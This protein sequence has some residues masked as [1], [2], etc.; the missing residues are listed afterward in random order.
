MQGA[1]RIRH[2]DNDYVREVIG[3]LGRVAPDARPRWGSMSPEAMTMHLVGAIK[4]SM[5]RLPYQSGKRRWFIVRVVRPLLLQGW[6]PMPRNVNVER[7]GFRTF[8]APGDAETLHAVLEEYL[9]LVQTGEL[10]PP[11]HPVFGELTVDEWARLHYI[12]FEHHLRQFG[13]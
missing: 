5:G 2:F 1:L 13:V 10:S 4:Y 12:H 8:T 3:R 6:I 7:Q 11:P 9:G